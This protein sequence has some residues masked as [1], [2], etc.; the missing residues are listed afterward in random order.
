MPAPQGTGLVTEKEC[1]KILTIAGISDIYSKTTGH[2]KTKLN[3]F[4]ACFDALSK[5]SQVKVQAEH[6]PSLGIVDG[7]K[8]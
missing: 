7:S 6:Y 8:L 1:R 3:L 4:K 5:L 2:T